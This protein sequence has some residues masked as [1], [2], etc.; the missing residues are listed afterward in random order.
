MRLSELSLVQRSVAFYQR[1]VLRETQK[2]QE[3]KGIFQVL[4]FQESW[5]A[6]RKRLR[7]LLHGVARSKK[8]LLA[9]GVRQLQ[10]IAESARPL[11]YHVPH[12]FFSGT[13]PPFFS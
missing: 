5:N 1:V 3:A 2:S 12:V 10:C 7:F 11:M 4:G 6:H 13:S 9:A 8:A